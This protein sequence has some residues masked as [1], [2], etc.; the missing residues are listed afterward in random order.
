MDLSC[1]AAGRRESFSER[2]AFVKLHQLCVIRVIVYLKADLGGLK[3]TKLPIAVFG[4]VD[5]ALVW[6]AND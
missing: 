4:F 5:C 6:L 1:G 2:S 3:G